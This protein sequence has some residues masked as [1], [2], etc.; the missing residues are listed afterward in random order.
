MVQNPIDPPRSTK[1]T[2]SFPV[3]RKQVRS[4]SQP[5]QPLKLP[6]FSPPNPADRQPIAKPQSPPPAID[7]AVE[8]RL[9]REG[10]TQELLS[11]Q[12]MPSSVV[13]PPPQ[14]VQEKQVKRKKP[15][16][17]RPH[18]FAP[19]GR[20][21]RNAQT[22]VAAI[23]SRASIA[24]TEVYQTV[25]PKVIET[26]QRFQPSKETRRWLLIWFSV[27]GSFTGITA[28]AFVWLASP[29]PSANCRKVTPESAGVQRLYCAQNLVRSGELPDLVAGIE[30]VENWSPDQPFYRDAQQSIA[31]W[32]ALILVIARGRMAQSDLPGAIDAVS[33]IPDSSPV[34]AQAQE[35]LAAWQ[36]EWQNGETIF[37]VAQDAI[38]QQNWR[39]ASQQVVELGYLNHD[40][41]RLQQADVLF[42]QV[43]REKTARESLTHAQKLAKDNQP[44]KLAEAITLLRKVAPDTYAAAE[45]EVALKQWSQTLITFG[46]DQWRSGDREG[47]FATAQAIPLNADLPT[48]GQ[49]LIQ[50]SQ[51]IQLAETSLET[52]RHKPSIAQVWQLMEAVAA[53]Q[54]IAPDSPFYE[55]AQAAMHTWQ[56][57]LQDLRQLLVATTIAQ[58]GDRNSLEVAIAQASQVSPDRPHRLQAQTLIANWQLEIQGLEDQ[59]F[60]A[61][62]E[63]WT[64]SGKIPDLQAAIAQ[65]KV[66]PTDRPAWT[67]AQQ[68]ISQWTAQIQT[69]EDQPFWDK[70]QK[71]AKQGKLLEAIDTAAKIQPNRALYEQA[72]AS[73]SEWKGKIRA[74]EIAEDQP[75]LDRAY[76]LAARQRLSMAIDV[77]SQIA[78]GRALYSEAQAAIDAWSNER[79]SLWKIWEND[80]AL[81]P[82][83]DDASGNLSIDDASSEF[84]PAPAEPLAES[85]D[86]TDEG[87]SDDR[88]FEESD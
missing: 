23:A 28:L 56:T 74:T 60:L 30:M 72:Q 16:K 22:T 2:P 21:K 32:S 81:A 84:S 38:K 68:L 12:G 85:A 59:P 70:A 82:T 33:Q 27:L 75:I 64:R 58:A 20:L 5:I 51:A 61:R 46:L 18:L 57:H 86:S 44:S 34:Y 45:A 43:V 10:I 87:Y 17:L 15:Q 73:I 4:N 11:F 3:A 80:P 52:P 39:L 67:K 25:A 66:I 62:A 79:D 54:H 47:A 14:P 78:P 9:M 29:P 26:S 19:V 35:A 88:F 49:D 77:A 24:S 71:L 36:K 63:R 42:K 31:D 7:P 83:T 8:E 50:I 48:E 76:G 41:W 40:Y 13:S 53:T 69:I 65:V 1:H 6:P 55:D 37:A